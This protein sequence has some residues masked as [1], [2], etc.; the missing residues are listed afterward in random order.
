MNARNMLSQVVATLILSALGNLALAQTEPAAAAPAEPPPARFEAFTDGTV[1]DHQTGLTWASKDNGGDVDWAGA[2][3]YCQL[4]GTGWELPRIDELHAIHLPEGETGQD[5]IGRLTCKLTPLIN[6]TGLT[7]WSQDAN[8][9]TEAWYLYLADGE[10]Y[11]Y[12]MTDTHG[13]RALCVRR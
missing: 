9:P 3:S 7:P 1:L 10:K 6:M 5:C 2:K 4:L 13:R 8:G 12:D 11:A